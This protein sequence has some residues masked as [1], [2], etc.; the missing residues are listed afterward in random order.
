MQNKHRECNIISITRHFTLIELLVVIAIIAILA[1]ILLPALQQA[2]ERAMSSTCINNLKQCGVALHMYA[3]QN[4]GFFYCDNDTGNWTVPMKSLISGIDSYGP[5]PARC[6]KVKVLE[7]NSSGTTIGAYR[8]CYAAPNAQ[9]D[10]FG[11]YLQDK[12]LLRATVKDRTDEEVSSNVSPSTI[13]MLSD[14]MIEKS[15]EYPE[16]RMDNRI[17][18]TNTGNDQYGRMTPLHG[19]RNN[20]LS[21]AGHVTS[22]GPGEFKKFYTIRGLSAVYGG[23]SWCVPIQTYLDPSTLMR[24]AITL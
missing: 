10:T 13:I 8:Q 11:F 5:S 14:N 2:R 24:V 16:S 20:L 23:L 7:T 1:A 15:S 17:T 19:G 18:F 3:D 9:V 12:G 4:R 22:P 6:P 21:I